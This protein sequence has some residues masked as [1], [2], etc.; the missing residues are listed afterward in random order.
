MHDLRVIG[1]AVVQ[2][3]ARQLREGQLRG[4]FEVAAATVPSYPGDAVLADH[5]SEREHPLDVLDT[6]HFAGLGVKHRELA[7]LGNWRRNSV[8]LTFAAGVPRGSKPD[9]RTRRGRRVRRANAAGC[10]FRS[11]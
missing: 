5:A 3:R 4:Q 8:T 11:T 6:A 7:I 10:V 2:K 1:I 9:C